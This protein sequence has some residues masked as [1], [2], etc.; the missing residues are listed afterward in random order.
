MTYPRMDKS[1][2]AFRTI[3]E[4]AEELDLPQHVLRFWESR[5]PQ[6][7]PL[8]RAGGRRYYRPRDIDLLRAVKQ[9]LYGEG[10]TIKGV[11]RLLREQG[12]V[13]FTATLGPAGASAPDDSLPS[14]Q[15]LHGLQD[16]SPWQDGRDETRADPPSSPPAPESSKLS[17]L[18]H[19]A[20]HGSQLQGRALSLI[21][22][23]FARLRAALTELAECE[24]ILAAFRRR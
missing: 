11:Q 12:V 1:A 3:S 9:L 10:Y 23:D 19:S 8:K 5:F 7:K 6:V 18:G 4:A 21:E 13:A 24:Q 14:G 2:D 17:S 20:G 15:V 22:K 16:S